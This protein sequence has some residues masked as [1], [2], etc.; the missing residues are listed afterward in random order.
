MQFKIIGASG[1]KYGAT[2]GAIELPR[3]GLKANM[4][5]VDLGVIKSGESLTAL[6]PARAKGPSKYGLADYD[7]RRGEEGPVFNPSHINPNEPSVEVRVAGRDWVTLDRRFG[8]PDLRTAN[9]FAETSFDFRLTGGT[10]RNAKP[11]ELV[12]RRLPTR[13]DAED[14]FVLLRMRVKPRP[15]SEQ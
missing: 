3:F 8:P 9:G 5:V 6:V 13:D 10:G 7:V 1:A 4:P 15:L 12:V 11:L 14:T 2:V